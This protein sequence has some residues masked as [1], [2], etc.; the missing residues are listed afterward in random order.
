LDAAGRLTIFDSDEPDGHTEFWSHIRA[1]IQ[2]IEKGSTVWRTRSEL[3]AK[4]D[5]RYKDAGDIN[6]WL[7][8]TVLT[9]TAYRI[10]KA[11]KESQKRGQTAGEPTETKAIVVKDLR[12]QR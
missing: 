7:D 4:N 11:S 10:L 5:P 9:G 1:E 3:K 8:A 12:S 2:V 6:H